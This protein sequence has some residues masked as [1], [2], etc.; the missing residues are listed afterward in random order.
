MAVDP[1]KSAKKTKRRGR[2][3]RAERKRAGARPIEDANLLLPV[4]PGPAPPNNR[5]AT[6]APREQSSNPDPATPTER[7]HPPAP[8]SSPALA[9]PRILPKRQLHSP[10]VRVAWWRVAAF[11]LIIIVMSVLTGAAVSFMLPSP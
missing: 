7:K 3:R 4:G 6:D 9:A 5:T 11:A 1:P 10:P 2:D 8:S